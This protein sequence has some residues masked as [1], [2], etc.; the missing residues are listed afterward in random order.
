LLRYR[1]WKPVLFYECTNVVDDDL[2]PADVAE[3]SFPCV[4]PKPPSLLTQTRGIW[5]CLLKI[6][7]AQ[8]D[9]L[10]ISEAAKRDPQSFELLRV[11]VA[12]SNQHSVCESGFG[13][14]L[15]LGV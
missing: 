1:G 9:Q 15:L 13:M 2:S 11:W 7:M 10:L 12:N 3:T 4:L 8:S 14:I 5:R 6:T